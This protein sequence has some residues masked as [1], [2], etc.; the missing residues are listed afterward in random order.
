M[1]SFG[2][3]VGLVLGL[4]SLPALA[5]SAFDLAQATP[6]ASPAPAAA[7]PA[8]PPPVAAPA[9]TAPPAAAAAAAKPKAK[10]KAKAPAGKKVPSA[11]SIENKSH[12]TLKSLQ[13]SLPGEQ[14]KTVGKL[15]KEV[16]AG[17]TARVVLKGAKG[18]EYKVKW[19]LEDGPGEGDVDL[20]GDHKIVVT[21]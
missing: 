13:I 6:P 14:G 10:A 2:V 7:P 12:S 16:V 20:C 8:A 5:A 17:K 9:A 4:A 11:V 3:C 15:D 19:E 1:K 18:C 21:E